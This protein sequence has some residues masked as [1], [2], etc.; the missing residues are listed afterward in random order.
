MSDF[1][2][3]DVMKGSL[4][5]YLS[6]VYY[7]KYNQDLHL[8]ITLKNS[9]LAFIFEN[10]FVSRHPEII[11]SDLTIPQLCFTNALWL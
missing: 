5:C 2:S 10:P 8:R 1:F 9:F 7:L 4:S 3:S 6:S 11:F